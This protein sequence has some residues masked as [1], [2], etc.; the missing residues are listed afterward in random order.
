[1]K[2]TYLMAGVALA[3][4]ATNPALA[5]DAYDLGQITVTAN[6]GETALEKTGT[7]VEVITEADIKDSGETR[8]GDALTRLPGVTISAN[9]G[10]GT[11]SNLRIRGLGG[12][13]VPV[14][15]DGIN[16]SDPASS[17]NGFDWGGITGSNISRIEVLKGSQ[18]ARYGT[19]AVGGVVN[20][21]SWTPTTDGVS[22][23]AFAEY[24]TYNTRRGGLSVGARS[25]RGE[26]SL[27]LSRVSTDGFSANSAG[28]ED[29]GYTEERLSLR[30]LYHLSD[31]ALVGFNVFW[32]DAEGEFDEWGGDGAA[33]YDETNERQNKGLRLFSEFMT[34]NVSHSLSYAYFETDRVSS[35]NGFDTTFNGTRKTLEY[36]AA[37]DLG[38]QVAMTVGSDFNREEASGLTADATGIFAEAVYAP[39]DALDVVTS[40]RHDILSEFA[41]KTTGRVALAWRLQPDLILRAQ[42]ATGYKPPSLYQLTSVYGDSTFEPEESTSFELG[43][44]KRFGGDNFVRATLF[45][46]DIDGQ[47]FWDSSSVRCASGFGCYE[48][49]DFI[50]Q[51]LEL[52]GQYALTGS[53]DLVGSYTL[54]DTEDGDGDQAL[55]VPR[56]DI[57]IGLNADLGA[58][59]RAGVSV[60][61]VAD[62]VDTVGAVDDYT[63]VN[64]NIAYQITEMAE[65]YLRVENLF[66][67]D[68]ETAAGY[69]TSGRAFYFGVRASF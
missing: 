27:S 21:Q 44:E 59:T 43:V 15:L 67:E 46:T 5:E 2:Q 61:H 45:R 54:T 28:T 23:E 37:F 41:D 33:P 48:V 35:S 66:D 42:A 6:Q 32:L 14:Y 56:H 19:N 24:G 64:A 53:V 8:L 50:A 12:D 1:M 38:S 31:T 51:G 65:A 62:R 68:Y 39:T 18:S 63:V 55:R 34:G 20:L 30:G 26:I 3:A 16:V 11:S 60:N 25:E 58:K 69:S 40:V 52:S 36:K 47:V 29:D 17:G 49:Q 9:G 4:L 13:Y 10:L 22:G 57:E 7:T